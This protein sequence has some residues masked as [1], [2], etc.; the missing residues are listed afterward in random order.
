MNMH[1]ESTLETCNTIVD[2]V[3]SKGDEEMLLV[4]QGF[5]NYLV[6]ATAKYH[7]GHAYYVGKSNIE[8]QTSKLEVKA[9]EVSPCYEHAFKKMAYE[10][11]KGLES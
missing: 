1:S 4:L 10:I 2:A 11:K 5:N 9:C 7:K 6:A 8:H 3:I